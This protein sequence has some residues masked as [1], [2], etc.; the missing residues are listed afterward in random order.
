MPKAKTSS[1]KGIRLTIDATT[2]PFVIKANQIEKKVREIATA[3]KTLN[4][5][6]RFEP[7]NVDILNQK[8][9][10][11]KDRQAAVK[12]QAKQYQEAISAKKL[13]GGGVVKLTNVFNKLK[14]DL[15]IIN[16][17]LTATQK[18]INDA[19]IKNASSASR[20][21]DKYKTQIRAFSFAAVFA[22]RSALQLRRSLGKIATIADDSVYNFDLLEQR[23]VSLAQQFGLSSAEI[24]EG[25]YFALSSGIK[26]T[27]SMTDELTFMETAAKLSVSGFSDVSDTVKTL[28]GIM[29]AYGVETKDAEKVANTLIKTQ[30]SGIITVHELSQFIGKATPL[31]ANLGVRLEEV[32]AAVATITRNGLPASRATTVLNRLFTDFAKSGTRVST[33]LK[34][35]TGK[36]FKELIAEGHT[37]YDIL[38]VVK[39][40]GKDAGKEFVDLFSSIRAAGGALGIFSNNGKDYQEVLEGMI[41]ANDGALNS[42]Y[43]G[44]KR[45]RE[46]DITLQKVKETF[47]QFGEGVLR[48]IKP[49]IDSVNSLSKDMKGSEYNC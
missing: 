21:I 40:S 16:S 42:A 1:L 14:N 6:L 2:E 38:K 44:Q 7:S 36:S 3:G 20:A 48:G 9:R 4:R 47:R 18:K 43:T 24:A 15:K 41:E 45:F 10:T 34:E 26:A 32:G 49:A 27:K 17:E 11:L 12:E 30:N 22:G 5:Q 39:D 8:L 33:I 46:F 13:K 28:A 31:A 37:L 25:W 23:V 29:N 19:N 35:E